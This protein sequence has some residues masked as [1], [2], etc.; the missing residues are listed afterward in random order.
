MMLMCLMGVIEKGIGL[1]GVG[2]V[3]GGFSTIF[4][5]GMSFNSIREIVNVHK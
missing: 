4:F 3:I 2:G 1:L 5:V